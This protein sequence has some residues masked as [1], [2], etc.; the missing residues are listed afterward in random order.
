MF[1]EPASVFDPRPQDEAC[2][3]SINASMIAKFFK[4]IFLC[5]I[6]PRVFDD[7]DMLGTGY[8]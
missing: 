4:Y 8:G 6:L 3:H 7:P 2:I 5:K 1:V